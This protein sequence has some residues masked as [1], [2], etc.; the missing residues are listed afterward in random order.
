MH[1]FADTAASTLCMALI[2]YSKTM[3]GACKPSRLKAGL[4]P[5]LLPA[6]H[7][8]VSLPDCH[9]DAASRVLSDL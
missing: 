8:R 7:G 6:S 1:R 3:A 2:D 5:S 9:Q 4:S